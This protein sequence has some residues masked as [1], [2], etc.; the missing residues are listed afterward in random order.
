MKKKK[1]FFQFKTYAPNT[2]QL[3]KTSIK[4]NTIEKRFR[5]ELGNRI[6]FNFTIQGFA[7][8]IT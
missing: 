4:I 2:T 6:M 3:K 5:I 1:E 7:S 8:S